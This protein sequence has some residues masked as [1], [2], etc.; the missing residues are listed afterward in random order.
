M[1]QENMDTPDKSWIEIKPFIDELIA[2]LPLQQ[3]QA[4]VMRFLEGRQENEIATS[5]ACPRSTVAS[6]IQ[7]GLEKLRGASRK[8]EWS[9]LSCS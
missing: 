2:A 7:R 1:R 5:L 4:L 6:W 9:S 3:R 8:K